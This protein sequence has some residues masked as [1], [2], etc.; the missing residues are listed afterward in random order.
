MKKLFFILS[1][2]FASFVLYAPHAAAQWDASGVCATADDV[3]SMFD[4]N[5]FVGVPKC[6][7]LC[8]KSANFCRKFVKSQGACYGVSFKGFYGLEEKAVCE[9]MADPNDRK[10]C[11]GNV[12]DTLTAIKSEIQGFVIDGDSQCD[13]FEA[14]CQAACVPVI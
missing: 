1:L 7:N 10:D 5:A 11:K 4:P 3:A 9:T 8:A 14:A 2:S 12:K 6:D 13:D